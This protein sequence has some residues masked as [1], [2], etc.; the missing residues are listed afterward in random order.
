MAL[1]DAFRKVDHRH[2]FICRNCLAL[3]NHDLT[4]ALFYYEGPGENFLGRTT[5]RYP[6]CS[7]ASSTRLRPS[8]WRDKTPPPQREGA[9]RLP[10][11]PR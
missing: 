2:W 8:S 11:I 1:L 3:Q 4:K 9:G 5:F 7:G 6:R 10:L